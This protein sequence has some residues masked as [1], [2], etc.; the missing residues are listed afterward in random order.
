MDKGGVFRLRDGFW[1]LRH[2][3][4]LTDTGKVI[5]KLHP[6]TMRNE[7]KALYSLHRA[8]LRGEIKMEYV[9]MQYQSFVAQTAYCT[10]NGALRSMDQFYTSLFRERP[11]YRKARKHLY[12]H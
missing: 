8:V 5:V 2:R 10:G 4:I 7:R 12:G 1:F 9:R 3:F 6:D 11:I